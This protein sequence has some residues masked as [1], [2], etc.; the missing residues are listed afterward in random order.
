MNNDQTPI[1]KAGADLR[2]AVGRIPPMSP[3]LPGGWHPAATFV[4]AALAVFLL[5]GVPILLTQT[6]SGDQPPIAAVASTSTTSTPA[7]TTTSVADTTTTATVLPS[8]GSELPFTTIL[9]EDFQG[10]FPGP[11][12]DA[13][14]PAEAGQTLMHWTGRGGSVELRWPANL[15]YTEGKQW[16]APPNSPDT[17][18]VAFVTIEDL[19]IDGVEHP[20]SIVSYGVLPTDVM[21]GPCDAVQ[22]S[23]F[24]PDRD[25]GRITL[26]GASFGLEDPERPNTLVL[27]PEL[28]RPR[29]LELVVDS[30]SVDEVPEVLECSG[31]S[32]AAG[33]EVPPIKSETI[34]DPQPFP[35]PVEALEALLA[36]MEG[37]PKTGYFELHEPDGSITYGNPLDDMS[38]DPRPENGLVISI[39]VIESEGTWKVDAWSSSGC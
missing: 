13:S 3:R 39:S 29:D 1:E 5:I 21:E 2:A 20:N 18:L 14:N 26:V 36:S 32:E 28:P 12:P 27:Y 15:E 23:V 4:G 31:G 37:W 24:G 7:E 22:M 6:R 16:G 11:S 10:P 34:S 35:T 9:P 19:T 30:L 17:D 33:F 38:L 25:D 8:C